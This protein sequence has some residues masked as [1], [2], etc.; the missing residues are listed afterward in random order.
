MQIQGEQSLAGAD[1][2]STMAAGKTL[3]YRGVLRTMYVM[4]CEEGVRSLYNGLV[5]GLHRQLCF[6]SVRIGLY[7]TVKNFY[8]EKFNS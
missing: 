3:K 7:D 5:A 1:S 8:I 6:A 4:S 2:S